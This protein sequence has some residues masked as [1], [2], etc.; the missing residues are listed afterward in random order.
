MYIVNHFLDINWT[1]AGI[2][3]LVPDTANTAC[4]NVPNET[5]SPIITQNP[6]IYPLNLT[7]DMFDFN[8]CAS[9]NKLSI[10]TQVDLCV[11]LYGKKPNVILLDH[12]SQVR[13]M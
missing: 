2:D 11:R 5:S 7:A 10:G 4:S 8:S 6:I 3:V 12:W 13:F 1:I 9:P